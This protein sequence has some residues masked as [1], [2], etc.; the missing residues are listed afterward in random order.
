MDP[1]KI[2]KNP[3]IKITGIILIL[4]FALFYNN[5]DSRSL[6]KRLSADN[7][8]ESL[9]LAKKQQEFISNNIKEAQEAQNKL[10]TE[11][12]DKKPENE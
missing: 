8:K 9:E 10:T 7:I 1:N 6:N 2:L 4:Y 11:Q 5:H 12:D 3:L